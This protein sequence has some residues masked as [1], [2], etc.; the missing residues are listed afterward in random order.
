MATLRGRRLPRMRLWL[1]R[2]PARRLFLIGI[3][4]DSPRD[5]ADELVAKHQIN[6]EGPNQYRSAY[7]AIR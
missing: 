4:C 7:M 6:D 2:A 5:A 1:G 3:V